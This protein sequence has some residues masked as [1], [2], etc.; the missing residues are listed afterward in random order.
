MFAKLALFLSL[1]AAAFAAPTNTLEARTL[2]RAT[3]YDPNG[4]YGACGQPLQNGDMIVALSSDQYLGGANCGRQLVAT[5]AGRSVTVTVRDLCPGCGA[6]GLDLSSGAFQQLAALAEDLESCSAKQLT[7]YNAI[8]IAELLLVLGGHSS[9]LFPE[10]H[11]V[12]SA[13]VPLLHPG[14]QQCI[15]ALG[16][17]ALRYRRIKTSCATLLSSSTSRYVSAVCSTL[18]LILKSEYEALVVDT[19]AKILKRDADLVARGSFVPLSSIRAI[20]SE[21]DAPLAALC[22]LMDEIEGE[23]RWRPGPLIDLLQ[24]RSNTGIR[25]I[26]DVISRLCTAVQRVWMTQLTAFLI[27]GTLVQPDP[28]ASEDYTLLDGAVPSCVSAQAR[29]SI[30]YVGRAIGT[31]KA[32]KWQKQLPRSLASDHAAL[33]QTALPEDQHAFDR[34]VTEIR[35]NISEWLWLNVLTRKDVEEAVDSL[36]TA[37]SGPSAMIREQDL[38]LALLRA[39]LG[40]TAQHDPT[41]SHLR[42]SLPTGPLRPLLPSLASQPGSSQSNELSPF[43]S[44]LLGTPLALHYAVSWPLDLFL[45]PAD[46]S[47]YGA[48]FA[49]LTALRKTHVRVH[50][51]WT[52]LSNAQ[53]AR[54]RWT[55]LGEGGTAEDEG[56]RRRLLRCG[57]G[58]VRDMGWFLDTLLGYL[59][60]DVVDA[61][62]V[63]LKGMLARGDPGLTA[64]TSTGSMRKETKSESRPVALDF[65]TLRVLHG[66]Y[67]ER[68]VTGCLLDNS[69]LMAILSPLLEVCERFVAQVERWGGDV[70][71]AL[72]FE[73]SLREGGEDVGAM[74]KERSVVVA[75]INE[76]LRELLD[77]FYEQLSLSTSQQPLTG[78]AADASRSRLNATVAGATFVS[79]ANY[80]ALHSAS[81]TMKALDGGAGD[82]RRH[83]E[84][85]LLR[86]D[87]N[88][89]FSAAKVRRAARTDILAEGGLA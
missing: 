66:T 58:I 52:A 59:M 73:G 38:N 18:S 26:A 54:R 49:Y 36:L 48:L 39:S 25:R 68:L 60:T 81:K 74:V 69:A 67:L 89:G 76:T 19:E 41:L 10:N 56:A 78:T 3:Y 6:N 29:E 45:Q 7:R 84:R 57:W 86:L 64:T 79:T 30:A 21:W 13:F 33:L 75:E 2:G 80:S 37:R 27:H 22:S 62:F 85:L 17:I 47:A 65:T 28:L 43:A 44:C 82:V 50:T 46:L 15:E 16:L 20:F 72:L 51:C 88:G 32:A 14:E 9:S 71:P 42:F 61:E 5:H 53:R 83:V 11:K 24:T 35:T 63:R 4:G 77:N 70:L 1:S 23:G 55:G 40:T 12:H 34:V 31:V 8:M 87:F